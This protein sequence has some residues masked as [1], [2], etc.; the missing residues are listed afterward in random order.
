MLFTVKPLLKKISDEVN[1]KF[2]KRRVSFRSK[3]EIKAV[4]YQSISILR[5]ASINSFL[6][7]HLQEMKFD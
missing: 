3:I 1:V 6:Q 5:Q 7:V 4:S 2:L